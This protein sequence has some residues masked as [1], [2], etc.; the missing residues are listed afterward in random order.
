VRSRNFVRLIK[1]LQRD[2]GF[3]A[4]LVTHDLDTIQGLESDVAV[5]AEQ[6]ILFRGSLEEVSRQEHPFIRQFFGS[7]EQRP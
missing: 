2:T 5:L 4:V 1:N 3:T 7:C 6:R